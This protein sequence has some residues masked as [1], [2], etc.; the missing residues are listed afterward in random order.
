MPHFKYLERVAVGVVLVG[1]AGLA[2]C[3]EQ[4]LLVVPTPDVVLPKDINGPSALPSGRRC[5]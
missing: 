5:G 3:N 1:A 4:D 2:A